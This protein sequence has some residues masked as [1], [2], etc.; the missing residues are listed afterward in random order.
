MGLMFQLPVTFSDVAVDFSSEEWRRLSPAQRALYRD[1]MLENYENLISVGKH[2]CPCDSGH[3]C[4][5][6]SAL[7]GV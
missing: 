5:L 2:G 1:V 4:I 7:L 6:P 3:F